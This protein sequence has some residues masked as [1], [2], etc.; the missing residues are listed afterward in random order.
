MLSTTC[1]HVVA[2]F[3]RN[4]CIYNTSIGAVMKL[5]ERKIVIDILSKLPF[6][7]NCIATPEVYSVFFF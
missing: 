3:Y 6:G 1:L 4:D 7:L 2:I 5:E